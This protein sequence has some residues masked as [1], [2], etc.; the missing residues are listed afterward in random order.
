MNTKLLVVGTV[1][2]GLI[3][4]IWGAVSHMV[5]VPEPVKRFPDPNAA[6]EFMQAKTQGNGAYFDTRGIFLILSVLPDKSDK[7]PATSNRTWRCSK[8]SWTTARCGA[9]RRCNTFW[10]TCSRSTPTASSSAWRAW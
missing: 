8:E 5:V 7:M 3:L 4:F 9:P 6:M 10:P 2:G 1:A